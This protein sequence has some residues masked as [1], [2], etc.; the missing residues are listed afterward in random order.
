MRYLV[1]EKFFRIGEDNTINHDDGTPAFRVDGKALTL[2]N[3]MDIYDMQNNHLGGVQ[4]KL[5]SMLPQYEIELPSGESAVLHRKMSFL[6]QRWLLTA[7]DDTIELNGNLVA[8]N[9]TF[10]RNGSTI[11]TVS[12]KWVSLTSTYGVDIVDGENDLLILSAVLG[13]EASQDSD[14]N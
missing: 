8:H 2:R 6:K 1:R 3:R 12:K 13:L 10:T 14:K 5:V 7:G 9:F 11:A 4:R